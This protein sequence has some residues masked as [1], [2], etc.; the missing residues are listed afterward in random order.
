MVCRVILHIGSHKTGSTSIQSALK[1]YDDG[2]TSY[3]DLGNTNHSAPLFTAFSKSKYGYHIWAKQGLSHQQ[4]DQ[5]A[6]QACT[7]LQQ[8]LDRSDRHTLILSG[9]DL[10][11]LQ[12]DEVAS[13]LQMLRGHGRDVSTVCY[14]RHPLDYATSVCQQL[15]KG[16]AANLP[17]QFSPAYRQRLEPYRQQLQADQLIV[18]RF[19][20][21]HLHQSCVVADFC[22]IIGIDSSKLQVKPRNESLPAA[23]I[24]A[25]YQLNRSGVLQFGD[26][27]LVQARNHLQQVLSQIFAGTPRLERQL[28]INHTDYSD[29][30]YLADHYGIT[31]AAK[32]A[33]DTASA[34]TLHQWLDKPDPEIQ[35]AIQHWLHHTAALNSHYPEPN[36]ALQRLYFLCLNSA[37]LADHRDLLRSVAR[38]C[39][40]GEAVPTEAAAALRRLARQARPGS[41]APQTGNG[42]GRV[43][44]QTPRGRSNP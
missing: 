28:L 38:Q 17:T 44:C 40:N 42:N 15:I 4:I 18:R 14:V 22:Q 31:F 2:Q 36:G 19:D 25:L 5:R 1:R 8:Q 39:E 3:A 24:K 27:L 35:Q 32:E 11:L 33:S 37:L 21:A 30:H 16:G 12:P 9:E 43:D 10:S 41:T 6:E 34:T 26:R 23:A 7:Q 13:L 20:R 29:C